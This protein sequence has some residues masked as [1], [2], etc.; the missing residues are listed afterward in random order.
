[1]A[2]QLEQAEASRRQKLEAAERFTRAM[3]EMTRHEKRLEA[4]SLAFMELEQPGMD[5]RVEAREVSDE[6]GQIASEKKLVMADKVSAAR[7]ADMLEA[8]ITRA[9]GELRRID[10][11]AAAAREALAAARESHDSETRI[12]D[13]ERKKS[14]LHM[15]HLDKEKRKPYQIIGASLADD[16][17]AP[18]NQPEVLTTVDSLRAAIAQIDQSLSDLRAACA[19]VDPSI[20]ITFYLLLAAV[21][22]TLSLFIGIAAHH[23]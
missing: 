3:D 10:A 21:L 6:L 2:A 11:A 9:R 18:L 23:R 22:F 7:E 5:A 13:R 4:R 19:A 17:I 14:S 1:L 12:L 16:R 15:A 20:L 8:V